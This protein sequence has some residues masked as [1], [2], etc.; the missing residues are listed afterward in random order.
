MAVPAKTFFQMPTEEL[1]AA[2][3]LR[4]YAFGHPVGNVFFVH[5]DGSGGTTGGRSPST[6]VTT[7]DA[8][9]NLCTAD[10]HDHIVV[11]PGHAETITAAGGIACDVAG[12]TIIGLG[13]GSNRPTVSLG[14]NT[15]ATITVSA[16]NVT[17]RNIRVKATVDEL[18]K[19]FNVT[20][21]YCTIDNV[22]YVDNTSTAQAI[23][24]LLTSAAADFLTVKNCYHVKTV[25]CAATEVWI[26]LVGC[27][28]PRIL[29]NTFFLALRDNAAACVIGMD[30]SVRRA[31]LGGNKGHVTGYTSGLVSAVIGAS[32]VTGIQYDSRWYC[33]TTIVTTIN[34]SQLASFEVYCSND[35]DKN[36]ILDPV[37][38]S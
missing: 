1:Q 29:N 31:E 22:E 36:G 30:A 21:A 17:I 13:E 5:H 26:S 12:I 24:F 19:I 16:A 8:A 10:N 11:L 28:S 18:V 25:A 33:D 27:D 37:A 3:P 14:T 6:A 2:F 20:A 34:D 32:G 35:L 9:I 23:Q 15:T 7:I 38:G 4:N